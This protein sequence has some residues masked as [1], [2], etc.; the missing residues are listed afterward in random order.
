MLHRRLRNLF[1]G[2]LYGFHVGVLA[3]MAIGF[4]YPLSGV[5][6]APF[7]EVERIWKLGPLRGLR[8]RLLDP[9]VTP[10]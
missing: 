5:A 4:P 8:R 6:F 9:A 10:S 1:I 3:T 2:G 7:F